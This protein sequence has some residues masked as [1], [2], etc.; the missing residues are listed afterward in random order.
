MFVALSQQAAVSNLKQDYKEGET[1]LKDAMALAIR[2]LVKSLDMTKL[3][4]EKGNSHVHKW[5]TIPQVKCHSNP[6]LH[7][8]FGARIKC[9]LY[10]AQEHNLSGCPNL[11]CSHWHI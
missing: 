1:T 9:P 3:T 6:I 11:P 7:L 8:L 5:I 2:V 10:A 4:A